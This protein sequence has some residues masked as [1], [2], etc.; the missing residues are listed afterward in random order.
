M[1]VI[2]NPS[3]RLQ[4]LSPAVAQTGNGNTIEV[5]SLGADQ[6]NITID[7]TAVSGTSPTAVFTLQRFDPVS[8]KYIDIIASA[9]VN[10]ISTITLACGPL[11]L[12]VANKAARESLPPLF[13]VKWVI[14]GT[15]PSFTF[16]VAV[17]LA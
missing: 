12:A 5:D 9:V 6:V 15:T 2:A 11:I 16:T 3:K 8:G 1:T 4:N 13:R 14:G 7:I 10:T 17:H